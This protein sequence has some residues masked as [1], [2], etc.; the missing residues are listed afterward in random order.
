ME[1]KTHEIEQDL[2]ETT[3]SYRKTLNFIK[4]LIEDPIFQKNI[5]K[6]REKYKLPNIGL[7]DKKYGIS[8][9]GTKFIEFPK[10]LNHTNF[11]EDVKKLSKNFGL[12]FLWSLMIENYVVYNDLDISIFTSPIDIIDINSYFETDFS[13]KYGEDLRRSLLE[14]LKDTAVTHPIAI[15]INPYASQREIIDFI[16]KMYKFK[17]KPLQEV[18]KNPDIKLGKIREK[19]ECTTLRNNFI[20]QHKHL[21][22]KEIMR[23]VTDKFGETL[24]Y[25]NIGKI[26]SLRNKK[27]SKK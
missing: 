16:K 20:Y 23:L 24:D 9:T 12:D 14:Y 15:L 19:K 26:I 1:R 3:E 22:R 5:L 6:L 21:P 4:S 25:G 13:G 7:S 8:S 10:K 11:S 17:I 27:D 2:I 18:Y